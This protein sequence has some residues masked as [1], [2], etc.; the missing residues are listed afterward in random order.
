VYVA[1]QP[2]VSFGLCYRTVVGNDVKL[3]NYGYKLHLVYG[4]TASPSEKG[5]HTINDSPEA[6]TF[7]FE[8]STVPENVTIQGKSY[9]PTSLITIDTTKLTTPAQKAALETLEGILYGSDNAEPRLPLP[10]EVYSTMNVA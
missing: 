8:I 5:Y 7:S 10:A 9:K 3:E 6:I 1:Q 2:R 4:C